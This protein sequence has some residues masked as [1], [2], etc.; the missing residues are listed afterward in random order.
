[1]RRSSAAATTPRYVS[2][3][4]S[5]LWL[6]LR[7]LKVSDAAA[8]TAMSANA[9]GLR[10]AEPGQVRHERAVAHVRPASDAREDLCRVRHLRHPLRR[11]ERGDLDGRVPGGRECVDERDLGR[12]RHD[13]GFVLQ[14]VARP[15]LDDGDPA[16]ERSRHSSS[17]SATPGCTNSPC[18]HRTAATRPALG[19]RI[20]SSI[21]IASSTRTVSP[22]P[23]DLAGL[24]QHL[25]HRGWHRRRHPGRRSARLPCHTSGGGLD[26][27]DQ[28]LSVHRN[29]TRLARVGDG[30]LPAALS[31]IDDIQTGTGVA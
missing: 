23:T 1:M 6:M 14:P 9:S 2:S 21:F 5:M 26:V 25:H 11:H 15:D 28:H 22:S 10:P 29:P 17:T 19:A 27:D 18:L 7:L 13:A 16:G 4:S 20:A 8:K 24:D 3:D 12:G 30:D 31:V